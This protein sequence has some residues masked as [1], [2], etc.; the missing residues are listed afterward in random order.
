MIRRPAKPPVDHNAET[1]AA[2]VAWIEAQ[3]GEGR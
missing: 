1:L 3:W 2:A